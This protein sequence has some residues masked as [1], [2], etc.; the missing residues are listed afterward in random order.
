MV[1]PQRLSELLVVLDVN[2]RLLGYELFLL[3]RNIVHPCFRPK[4]DRDNFRRNVQVTQRPICPIALE[5]LRVVTYSMLVCGGRLLQ[6]SLDLI[7][8]LEAHGLEF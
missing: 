3:L 2:F 7:A 6:V 1:L 5:L 4:V 8:D